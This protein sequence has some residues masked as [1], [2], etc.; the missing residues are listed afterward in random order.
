MKR[1]IFIIFISL[2]SANYAEAGISGRVP[3]NLG[4]VAYWTLDDGSGSLA[5]DLS[6]NGYT[7]TLTGSTWT[8]G[9]RGK[10]ISMNGSAEYISTSAFSIN[11]SNVDN[12]SFS[13]WVKNEDPNFT[14]SARHT[15]FSTT[16]S[17]TGGNWSIEINTNHG[18]GTICLITPG[19]F[20]FCTNGS[21]VPDNN[22]H[23]ITFVRRGAGATGEIYVD[24]VLQ[25]L[26][27][28]TAG[29]FVDSGQIKTI[30]ARASGSPTQLWNGKLD[31]IRLYNRS[32]SV[33]EVSALYVTNQASR[34]AA[35]NRSLIG[36]W[37][38]DDGTGTKATDSSGNRNTGTITG[39]S[40]VGGKLG[41]ALSF[42]GTNTVSL[43]T[44]GGYSNAVTIAAWVKHT[45]SDT[46][47]D[48]V[49]GGCGD[50]LLGFNGSNEL[51]WGGQCNNPFAG[52]TYATNIDGA[53]H[54]V[55]ATYDGSTAALYVDG[56]LVSSGAASGSFTPGALTIGSSGAS[57][58]YN[59][60]I[61]DVRI[62]SRALTAAE[63]RTLYDIGK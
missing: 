53:W 23:Q 18:N 28:S 13:A 44:V 12:V 21:A 20:Q 15:F 58:Y 5:T 33:A 61:D 4:L 6:G 52:L 63:V 47:D 60:L 3:N 54:H 39:A 43:G 32:L 55:I 50:F 56:V 37:S 36:Y 40:Y 24:A 31:D 38:F 17:N 8:T 9:R 22:W 14:Q 35:D 27:D 42:S 49:A 59:G 2:L 19:I 57:E 45:S 48:I 29:S 1:F 7:G 51:R 25:A 62:Y 26:V 30:G 41:K 16:N 46:W 34:K 10:A 11:G